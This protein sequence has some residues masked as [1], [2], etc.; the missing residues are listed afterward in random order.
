MSDP[1]TSDFEYHH[2]LQISALNSIFCYIDIFIEHIARDICTRLNFRTSLLASF[3]NI[4][5]QHMKSNMQPNLKIA[6]LGQ[7]QN[8]DYS[9]WRV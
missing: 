8:S 5:T 9:D 3:R 1:L 4:W 6:D 7:Q 2:G